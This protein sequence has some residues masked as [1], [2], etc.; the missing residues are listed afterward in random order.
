MFGTGCDQSITSEAIAERTTGGGVFAWFLGLRLRLE[1]MLCRRCTFSGTYRGQDGRKRNPT[2]LHTLA[3]VMVGGDFG[4]L[5][6]SPN[7][8]S[9]FMGYHAN[10]DRS[11]MIWMMNTRE[12]LE[13]DLWKYPTEERKL[14]HASLSDYLQFSG[15]YST[16]G[17]LGC[18]VMREQFSDYRPFQSPWIEGSGLDDVV[19][20][21]FPFD[22]LFDT[23]PAN[24]WGYTHREI[25]YNTSP[26]RTPYTYDTLESYYYE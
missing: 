4:D 7:D 24:G 11:H 15:P 17:V 20:A 26:Q 23:P 21:G 5:L 3:H 9:L 22:T 12:E 14:Q 18:G 19:N 1:S 6:T 13:A 8:P 10:G 16:Y 2:A 25:I